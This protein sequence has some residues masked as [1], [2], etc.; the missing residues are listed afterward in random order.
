MDRR[1]F[2][3][4]AIWVVVSPAA[5]PLIGAGA[6]GQ[7][8]WPTASAPITGSAAGDTATQIAFLRK[9]RRSIALDILIN[10]QH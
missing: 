7:P 6:V 9:R 3:K 4:N 5:L 2:L 1:R 10:E 8:S